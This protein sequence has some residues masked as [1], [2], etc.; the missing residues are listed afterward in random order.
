MAAG[1]DYLADPTGAIAKSQELAAKAFNAGKTWFLV[2]G[3]TVGIQVN[4]DAPVETTATN[5]NMNQCILHAHP[6][7]RGVPVW[8]HSRC[9]L[10]SSVNALESTQR[11]SQAV[12]RGLLQEKFPI[13]AQA[14]I[15]ATCSP[16]DALLV[17]R[18]CHMAAFSG[19]ALAGCSPVWIAPQYEAELELAQGVSA[20]ALEDA[21]HRAEQQGLTPK[22]A[23]VVSPTYY[24]ACSDI[25]GERG[26]TSHMR[27]S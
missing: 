20:A 22:A 8:C 21:F 27:S 16:G 6:I 7:S 12:L 25:V 11:H 24:G 14:A 26:S 9:L 23:L 5:Q 10:L 17:A 3:T 19:M 1:L 4:C 15:M 13:F 2:N 18:N